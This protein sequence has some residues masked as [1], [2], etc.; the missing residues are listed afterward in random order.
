MD[1]Y[2]KAVGGEEHPE[3]QGERIN[4]TLPI[5]ANKEARIFCYWD[6]EPWMPWQTQDFY[7]APRKNLRPATYQRL[8]QNQWVSSENRFIDEQSYHARVEPGRPDLA[9]SIF[10]GSTPRSGGIPRPSLPS[11]TM[12]TAIALY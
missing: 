8:H 3:G 9:G 7:D 5:Y 11:S 12:I 2:K 4:P 1:L 6:H 10:I